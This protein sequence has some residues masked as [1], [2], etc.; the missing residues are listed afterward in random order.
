MAGLPLA[1]GDDAE[2]GER[3]LHIQQ[4]M[5]GGEGEEGGKGGIGAKGGEGGLNGGLKG[6]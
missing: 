2:L 1:Q 4:D 6:G 3:T 5:G